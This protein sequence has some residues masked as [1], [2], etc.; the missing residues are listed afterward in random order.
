MKIKVRRNGKVRYEIEVDTKAPLPVELFKRLHAGDPL[1][2][3]NECDRH[4][5]LLHH[6]RD[7]TDGYT[8]VLR[9]EYNES[10]IL[11]ATDCDEPGGAFRAGRT[12]GMGATAPARRGKARQPARR[13]PGRAGFEPVPVRARA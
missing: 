13:V 8:C 7:V 4:L 9:T 5:F 12:R 1:P 10:A 6:V 3:E 11:D 2:A